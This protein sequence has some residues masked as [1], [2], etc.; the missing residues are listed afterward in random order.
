MVYAFLD[1]FDRSIHLD[2][3]ILKSFA[4]I[5]LYIHLCVLGVLEVKIS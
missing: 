2:N 5:I 4:S 1:F 3:L